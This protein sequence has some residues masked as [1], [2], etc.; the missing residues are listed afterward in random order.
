MELYYSSKFIKSYRR[1]PQRIKSLAESKE[2]VFNKD[3]FNKILQTHKLHGDFAGFWALSVNR[4]YRIVFDFLGE[5][6]VR[7]YDIGT[8]DIYK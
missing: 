6:V 7:F 8:H 5:N 2:K 3:P 4:S 1:L